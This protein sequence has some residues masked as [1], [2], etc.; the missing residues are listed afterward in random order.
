MQCVPV[1]DKSVYCTA[2]CCAVTVLCSWQWVFK[3]MLAGAP[4]QRSPGGR[5]LWNIVDVRDCG[6]AHRLAL[7]APDLK[8]GDRFLLSAA[9]PSSELATWQLQD[10]VR[11]L[12]PLSAVGAAGL[13]AGEEPTDASK[14]FRPGVG[15]RSYCDKAKAKLGLAPYSCEACLKDTVESYISLGLLSDTG[16]PL[17]GQ[18][19]NI[20]P[21]LGLPDAPKL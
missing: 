20:A 2:F 19:P 14:A 13:G 4:M 15:A 10:A 11:E 8:T 18:G 3:E 9:D 17:P 21:N 7:E 5:M 1:A 16:G 12:Y 6:I